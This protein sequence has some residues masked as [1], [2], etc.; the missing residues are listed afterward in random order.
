VVDGQ[1]LLEVLAVR[2][3]SWRYAPGRVAGRERPPMTVIVTLDTGDSHRLDRNLRTDQV[4][5]MINE[6]R[7]EGKLVPFQNDA[8]PSRTIYIDPDHVI[9]VKNDG[10]SY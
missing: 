7:G 6:A 1:V 4:A 2:A 10:Y 9:S 3:S 5:S 8:T